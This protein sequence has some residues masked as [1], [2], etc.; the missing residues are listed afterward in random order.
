MR[1]S[2]HAFALYFLQIRTVVG[3]MVPSVKCRLFMDESLSVIAFTL[4]RISLN[5]PVSIVVQSKNSGPG[6]AIIGHAMFC[7][8]PCS[9]YFFVPDH[10]TNLVTW[11]WIML[12]CWNMPTQSNVQVTRKEAVATNSCSLHSTQTNPVPPSGSY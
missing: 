6:S 1:F 8:H 11:I 12:V 10:R 7:C 3:V 4:P 9:Q 5:V 2:C